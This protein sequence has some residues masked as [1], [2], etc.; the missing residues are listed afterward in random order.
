MLKT[1]NATETIKNTGLKTMYTRVRQWC[2]S[3]F[4]YCDGEFS[5]WYI[6]DEWWV[7]AC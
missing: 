3:F 2:P 5:Q 7:V 1:V 4:T 6:M